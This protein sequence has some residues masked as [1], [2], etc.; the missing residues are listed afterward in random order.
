MI[1]DDVTLSNAKTRWRARTEFAARAAAITCPP[2]CATL[3]PKSLMLPGKPAGEDAHD[4]LRVGDGG[5]DHL[6]TRP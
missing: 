1:V 2:R 4:L 5:A 3:S 6:P